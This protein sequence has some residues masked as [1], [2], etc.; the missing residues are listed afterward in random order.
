MLISYQFDSQH[1]T[2]LQGF[3]SYGATLF[4]LGYRFQCLGALYG[5]KLYPIEGAVGVEFKNKYINIGIT[6]NPFDY[7]HSEVLEFKFGVSIP[8]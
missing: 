2:Y 3:H 5:L 8:L 7:Q 4:H 1:S 6:S